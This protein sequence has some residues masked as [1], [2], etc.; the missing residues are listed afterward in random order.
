M[1]PTDD[2]PPFASTV[3]LAAGFALLALLGAIDLAFDLRDGASAHAWIESAVVVLGLGAASIYA[4]RVRD[5]AREAHELRA[6][7][8]ELASSLETTRAEAA[9]W[10]RDAA[11]LITGLGAAIDRQL[12]RWELTPAEQ[13]IALLLLKGL[14]HK[15]I[16][17]VRG[18]GETTVRQ[19]A[20][21]VYRKAGLA[22][23]HDLAAFFLEDL[24]SPQRS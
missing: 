23:R 17:G 6:R 7:T 24:L 9:R 20:R 16:A 22:G 2:A 11:D 10:Q 18:V 14:S 19:Q 4:R 13:E 8:R 5:L 12:E 1:P 15:E 21:A 3:A